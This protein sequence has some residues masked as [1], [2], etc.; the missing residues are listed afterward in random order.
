MCLTTPCFTCKPSQKSNSVCIEIKNRL[1]E[2]NQIWTA[3]FILQRYLFLVFFLMSLTYSNQIVVRYNKINFSILGVKVKE[4]IIVQT[5]I[6]FVRHNN[7]SP[8]YFELSKLPRH[9]FLSSVVH[10][11]LDDR[12]LRIHQV[13]YWL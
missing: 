7:N 6:Y 9:E 1:N 4:D 13:H 12:I 8:D 10:I 3:H 5:H 11:Y 2:Y